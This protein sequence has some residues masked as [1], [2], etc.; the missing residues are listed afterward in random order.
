V[1]ES[2][3]TSNPEPEKLPAINGSNLG[4]GGRPTK[5]TA[6]L[7]AELLAAIEGGATFG[8]ACELVSISY[9]IFCLW[10]RQDP[11]FAARID[12][13]SARGD[14]ARLKTINEHGEQDWRAPAWL[15]ERRRPLEYGRQA[16]Q[17]NVS[18]NAAAAVGANGKPPTVFESVVLSDVDFIKLTH[19]PDYSPKEPVL[20]GVPPELT[21]PLQKNGEPTGY[22]ISES[23]AAIDKRV[24]EQTG[25][26]EDGPLQNI[27]VVHVSD[28]EF[29]ALCGHPL[30]ERKPVLIRVDGR[31]DDTPP[32]LADSLARKD[33]NIVV[34]S[35]SV[36]KVKARRYAEIHARAKALLDRVTNTGNSQDSAEQPPVAS[37]PVAAELSVASTDGAPAN[38]PLPNK[39]S[40]WWA[41][42]IF[43]GGVI[44][45]DDATQALRLILGESR[46]AHDERALDFQT[47]QVVKSAFCQVLEKL[48]G[49]DLGWRTMAQIYERAQARER[50]W[51]DH[52]PCGSR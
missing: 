31:Q 11:D 28:V 35:E 12:A 30:Y 21:P 52:C 10:R 1:S 14:M 41:K 16:A 39:P 43:G 4:T 15:L 49:S 6:E 48:T 3:Q 23:L 40:A 5:R 25:R 42:F 27:T 36:A 18:A 9:V 37:A 22:V 47:E 17:I 34:T 2:A 46:I 33:K 13:A 44:S 50:L 45:R 24:L 29:L 51:A 7:E 32:E 19:H 38:E 20:A 8:L 26:T